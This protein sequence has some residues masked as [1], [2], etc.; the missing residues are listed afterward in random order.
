MQ[1][2]KKKG[3]QVERLDLLA[4]VR[5][6]QDMEGLSELLRQNRRGV[7][8]KRTTDKWKRT[9]RGVMLEQLGPDWMDKIEVKEPHERRRLEITRRCKRLL[10]EDGLLGGCKPLMDSLK[11]APIRVGGT[12][13]DR[14]AGWFYDDSPKYIK[15][16]VVQIITGEDPWLEVSLYGR[17]EG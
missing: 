4:R 12:T 9:F 2:T 5:I 7:P 16:H 8:P 17:Q 11:S 6:F 3:K 15:L 10:D 1:A 13:V 14:S